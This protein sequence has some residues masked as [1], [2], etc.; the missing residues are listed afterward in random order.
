M[1]KILV[2]DWP[3]RLGHW[4]LVVA[5]AL[6]W[7]SGNSERWRLLHVGAGGTVLAIVLYRLVWGCVGS[8]HARFAAFVRP[9]RIVLHY[10]RGLLGTPEHCT[11]H[12]PAGGW[13]IVLLLLFGLLT[14]I[15]GWLIWQQIG[16]AG[17]WLEEAHEA[18]AAIML[19]LAG[20]HVAGV[21]FGSLAH[22]ENLVAA[23][24]TGRKQG[25]ADQAI[26]HGH[27]GAAAMLLLWIAL[28]V[29]FAMR[30]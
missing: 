20:M 19:T 18:C 24:I 1:D 13:A 10:L 27:L 3:V 12:N 30:W 11:G 14:S 4:L 21:A 29:W 6:A 2:W 8:R 15:S 7:L 9:P 22:R 5:F 23:M 26:A 16:E 25:P 28:C 17:E